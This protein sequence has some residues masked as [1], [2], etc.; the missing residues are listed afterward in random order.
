MMKTVDILAFG[1][2]PDDVEIGMGG[3]IAKHVHEGF[4]VGI[5]DLTE[6]EMS[7]NGT[8]ETRRQEAAE[9]SAVLGLSYRS[10][11]GL[12]DRGLTGSS[13]QIEAI[14][15]EIR[16]LRP[17]LVF[18]P[19]WV[20]RHPDH[21]ACSRLLEEAVFNA[22]L[23]NYLPELPSVQVEQL[24]FYYINDS[25][26]VSLITDISEYV[27]QKIN[28]LRAYRSQFAPAAAGEDRVQTPLTDRYVERVTAR[29]MLLGQTRGW[30]YAEGFAM[31]RP[32]AVTIF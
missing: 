14:V 29:D 23:R 30:A 4:R 24:Y 1:A 31:K 12:P 6:A 22:K 27:E 7:S 13:E 32:Y 18:A 19:Y 26:E 10:C 21:N 15:R 25:S 28:A 9:A 17:R 11:L 3:T 8:V 16:R 20:D 5:C 2:H